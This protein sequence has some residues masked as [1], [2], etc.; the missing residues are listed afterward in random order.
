MKSNNLKRD[1]YLKRHVIQSLRR[2]V[3]YMVLA[4]A[5]VGSLAIFVDRTIAAELGVL[6]FVILLVKETFSAYRRHSERWVWQQARDVD[7]L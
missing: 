4:A 2:R 7:W 3:V 1:Q 6:T 5:V